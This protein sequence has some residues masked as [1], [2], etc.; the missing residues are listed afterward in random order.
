MSA[1]AVSCGTKGTGDADGDCSV[2]CDGA[3]VDGATVS[4][5]EAVAVNMSA[6]LDSGPDVEG[7]GTRAES[8][9]F[10]ISSN[11]HASPIGSSDSAVNPEIEPSNVFAEVGSL[12]I[13]TLGFAS[14]RA[15]AAGEFSSMAT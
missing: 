9:M 8:V 4:A 6:R 2:L 14:T 5:M 15:A 1:G 13:P 3:G 12:T 10:G 7:A 11:A